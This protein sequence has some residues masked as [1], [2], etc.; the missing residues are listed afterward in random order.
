MKIANNIC[1]NILW[2][3]MLIVI[4]SAKAWSVEISG[5]RVWNGPENSRIVFDLSESIDYKLFELDNPSRVVVDIFDAQY[6]GKLPQSSALG[7]IVK[8]IRFGIHEESVRFVFDLQ[9]DVRP[10]H[11]TLKPYSVYGHRLVID[12]HSLSGKSKSS[13]KTPASSKKKNDIVVVI[14]PGHGGEDPGAIGAKKTKEKQLVLQIAKKLTKSLNSESGIRAILTRSGDYYIPLRKRTKI[15]VENQADLFVSI[16]ADAFTRRS[17]RGISV[18]ALSEKGATSERARVIANKEN[19]SDLL[20]GENLSD[21]PDDL[22]G[23]LAHLAQSEQIERS[24]DL[25]EMIRIRL[26]KVGKLHGNAVEQAGF[27]VLKTPNIPSLLVEVGFISNPTEESRLRTNSYQKKIV[28]GIKDAI[29]HYIGKYP[30]QQDQW[31]SAKN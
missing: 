12:L 11:F 29:V 2:S 5:L 26:G 31:R 14:D 15:A 9:S 1:M 30:W 24:L 13:Q 8:K 22:V 23:V 20:A 3:L 4:G 18:F 16:H 6:D 21:K 25:G 7:K 10:E 27:V 19:A 28:R 17:A